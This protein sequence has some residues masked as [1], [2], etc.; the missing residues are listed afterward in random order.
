MLIGDPAEDRLNFERKLNEGI[1][2]A[3]VV[4]VRSLGL[5]P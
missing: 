1:D 3:E 5:G 2:D 4:L